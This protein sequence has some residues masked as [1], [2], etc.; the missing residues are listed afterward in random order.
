MPCFLQRA[1][2]L[3]ISQLFWINGCRSSSCGVWANVES[4]WPLPKGIS[5]SR[6]DYPTYPVGKHLHFHFPQVS[7]IGPAWARASRGPRA[8]LSRRE[9]MC[10]MSLQERGEGRAA[11]DQDTGVQGG[12][13]KGEAGRDRNSDGSSSSPPANGGAGGAYSR[14]GGGGGGGD[15]GSGLSPSASAGDA[16]LMAALERQFS[17]PSTPAHE[18][19]EGMG[20]G[21]PSPS[22]RLRLQRENLDLRWRIS[23][24]RNATV[25]CRQCAGE[26]VCE[27][28][29]CAGTGLF[30]V[31]AELMI[32]PASG[33]PSPCPV[34]KSKGVEVCSRCKG[35]GRIAAWLFRGERAGG[36]S[37]DRG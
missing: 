31:G 12:T 1:V 33:R 24:K 17:R 29:F 18:I 2:V 23:Q 30:K 10:V 14:G 28:R 21:S 19:S 8:S 4:R 11:G 22:Q 7:W 13:G 26:G 36:M 32:H 3:L 16:S 6:Y 37:E 5:S 9:K 27:C 20:K 15:D 34:C 25:C 35:A